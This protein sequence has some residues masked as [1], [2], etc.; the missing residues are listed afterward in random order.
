[1]RCET[2]HGSGSIAARLEVGATFHEI[3]T[4]QITPIVRSH[5]LEIISK[6]TLLETLMMMRREPGGNQCIDHS[7]SADLERRRFPILGPMIGL[8][9]LAYIGS[10]VGTLLAG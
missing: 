8:L 6:A 10:A 1:M 7:D 4:K 5:P 3:V 9:L 2:C